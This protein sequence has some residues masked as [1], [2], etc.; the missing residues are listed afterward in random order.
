MTNQTFK[1]LS[2]ERQEEIVQVAFEE[3]ALKGY[4]N[5]SLSVIIKKLGLAKGSFYRYFSSK[6]ELFAYL[7]DEAS[8]RRL[9]NLDTLINQDG[10]DFFELIKQNFIDKI[11]FD[12]EYPLIGGFLYQIMHEK[13]NSEVTDIIKKIYNSV[14]LQ[15]KNIITLEKFKHQLKFVEPELVAFQIFHMQLWLYDYVAFKFNIDFETNIRNHQ[16]VFNLPEEQ[17]IQ[18]IDWSVSMLKNG[19]VNPEY[20]D[21]LKTGRSSQ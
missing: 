5:A 6:K 8:G 9:S 16:P 15:T 7:V 21:R 3:F 19:I 10:I 12:N 11:H 13:D 17:L 20:S 1:N 2:A 4:Q 14:I 18:L